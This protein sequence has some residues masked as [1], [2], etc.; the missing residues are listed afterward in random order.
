[1]QNSDNKMGC[2]P[3]IKILFGI[4]TPIICS[5][6]IQ[7]LY[8]VVDSIYV[9][10]ISDNA[11]TAVS[12]VFPFQLLMIAVATGSG[13]GINIVVSSLLGK[14]DFVNVGRAVKNCLILGCINFMFL[15]IPGFFG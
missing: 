5:M 12:I 2:Q 1:M 7:A 15:G 9:A 13:V 11:L 8:N 6:M 4:S 14:K 10:H 3:V